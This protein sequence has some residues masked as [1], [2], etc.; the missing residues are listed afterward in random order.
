MYLNAIFF[1]SN[2]YGIKTAAR[3]FFDKEPI[4]L[5]VEEGACLVGMVNKPTRYNPAI[6]PDKSLVRRNHVLKQMR[7]YGYLS[8]DEYDSISALPIVLSYQQQD[9]NAG[10]GTYFRDMLRRTMNA[11]EPRKSSYA[12]Y[13]D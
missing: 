8:R 1:G 4:D 13:I 9:H 5:T 6:N 7:K 11:K 2:A 10:T 12:N 3:T